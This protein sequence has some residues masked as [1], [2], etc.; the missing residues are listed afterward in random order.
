MKSN[1]S[2]GA[3]PG[4]GGMLLAPK[5]TQEIANTRGIDMGKDCISPAKHKEF[6]NPSE[7]LKFV[8]K[9]KKLSNGKPVGIKM[10][11]G[12]PWELISIIKAMVK[13]EK[14]Y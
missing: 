13:R 14:V 4:H 8:E 1:L 7:L 9:L 5:V 6:S 12:H 2:Q 11:V 10:C 3:K